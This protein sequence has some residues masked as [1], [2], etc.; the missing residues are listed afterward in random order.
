MIQ[1]TAAIKM[2]ISAFSLASF[3]FIF[4]FLIITSLSFKKWKGSKTNNIKQILIQRILGV[5]IFGFVSL[6]I[7]K[8]SL[9]AEFTNFGGGFPGISSLLWTILLSVV[10]IPISLFNS[11][12]PANLSQYPQIRIK[13]WSIPL[14]ILSA[15]SWIAYLLAY[16]FLFR[17]L[18]LF[19]SVSLL[20]VW[21]AIILNTAVYSLV[22]IPKGNK[23]MLGAI[24]FGILIS[25]L[26]LETG[27]FWLAFIVHV[28]LAISNEWF[29]IAFNPEMHLK[30]TA[31]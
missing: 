25:Y 13:E 2:F 4:Y 7:I 15:L 18:L 5:F 6:L 1:N 11:K 31:I 29:S 20:G 23:E 28:V 19:S 16:E 17:G 14:I 3:G 12:K 22:H 10:I 26:T 24:P 30:K 27:T 21:P 9:H 8:V